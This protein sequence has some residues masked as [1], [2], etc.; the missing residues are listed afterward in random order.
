MHSLINSFI[1]LFAF[2]EKLVPK[3]KCLLNLTFTVADRAKIDLNRAQYYKSHFKYLDNLVLINF[4][5]LAHSIIDYR[6]KSVDM[7][8]EESSLES[9]LY[10]SDEHDLSDLCQLIDTSCDLIGH[11]VDVVNL[12]V[13][14]VCLTTACAMILRPGHIIRCFKRCLFQ[15]R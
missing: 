7:C 13:N 5:T 10:S 6:L 8:T 3:D 9:A 11:F 1:F 4:N 15:L 2:I 14:T 12:C